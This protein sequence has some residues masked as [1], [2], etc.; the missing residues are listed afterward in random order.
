[1]SGPGDLRAAVAAGALGANDTHAA[2]LR[3][4][5]DVARAIFHARASSI[6]LHDSDASELVFAAVSGEG[7]KHLVGTRMPAARGIAGWVLSARQPVVLEDV[8]ADP[9]FAR[10][11][12]E[13][14]GYVPSGL[15]AVP[16]LLDDRA[17]G[18]L[19]VLDRPEHAAFTLP[20][21]DLLGHFAHQAALA[22]E[23]ANRAER[24]RTV[25]SEGDSELSDIASLVETI[26]GLDGSRHEAGLALLRALRSLLV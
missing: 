8:A 25:L 7:S 14:T 24:A 2:L 17:L 4:I 12:A 18:V 15:M 21:M 9:R 5:V 11:V 13:S 23:L 20:E 1:M 10:D 19:S 22:L 16:L 6:M 26:A 3:S